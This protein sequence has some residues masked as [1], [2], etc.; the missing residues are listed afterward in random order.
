MNGL[1]E[2][3]VIK[4]FDVFF[5]PVYKVDVLRMMVNVCRAKPFH[6]IWPGKLEDG[7]LIYAEEDFK[8]YKEYDVA[9]YDVTC[10]K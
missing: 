1:P 8:D 9:D 6:M 4:E 5:N 10:I 3:V 7:K 2:K